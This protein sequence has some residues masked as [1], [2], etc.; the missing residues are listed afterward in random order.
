MIQISKI[1]PKK[2]LINS[3]NNNA[4]KHYKKIKDKRKSKENSQIH[5]LEKVY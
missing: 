4:L 1:K 2:I 3:M 5:I